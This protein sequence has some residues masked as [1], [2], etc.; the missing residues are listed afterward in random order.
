MCYYYE[1]HTVHCVL[2][3]QERTVV[4]VWNFVV[5]D[6]QWLWLPMWCWG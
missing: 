2:Y 1:E 6:M 5:Y 3:A 4:F